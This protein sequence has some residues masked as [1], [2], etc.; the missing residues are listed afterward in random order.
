M[1][2][3]LRRPDWLRELDGVLLAGVVISAFLGAASLLAT[4]TGQPVEVEAASGG[5]L[6]PDALMNARAGT[7]IAPEASVSLRIVDPSGTQLGLAALAAFPSYALTTAM[8]VLLWRLVGAARRTDPFTM[9]TARRLRTLGG[10]LL[11]GGPVVCVVEFLARFALTDT[12]STVGPS[13]SFDPGVLAV[14]ALAG[15]G[16]LAIGEIVRRGQALRAELDEV[17]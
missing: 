6:S 3:V 10:V 13:T 16:F 11:V 15:F 7:V 12:V 8:L 1:R 4:L 2:T 5:V 14:W 9:V 17:V